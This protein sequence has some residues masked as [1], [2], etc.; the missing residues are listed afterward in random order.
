MLLAMDFSEA[1]AS[2]FLPASF[3]FL[4]SRDLGKLP[5]KITNGTALRC[6]ISQCAWKFGAMVMRLTANG[7]GMSARQRSTSCSKRSGGMFPAASTGKAPFFAT[8]RQ[9][10]LWLIQVIAPHRMGQGTP[11]NSFPRAH[12]FSNMMVILLFRKG[13]VRPNPR[14]VPPP[15]PARRKRPGYHKTLSWHPGPK[16]L[17]RGSE[18]SSCRFP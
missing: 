17:E 16:A 15:G 2:T 1:K 14:E 18:P 8:A 5:A 9:R 12:S 4:T 3:I 11:R 6:T 10:P 13:L 7:V